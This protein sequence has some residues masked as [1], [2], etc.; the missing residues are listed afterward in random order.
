M[1]NKGH[2]W[3]NCQDVIETITKYK[4][5]KLTNKVL[6]GHPSPIFWN[7]DLNFHEFM[8]HRKQ[9][10]GRCSK[11][12]VL[13]IALPFCVPTNPPNCGYCL[14]PHVNY[15][16]QKDLV[17]YLNYLRI[18]GRIYKEYLHQEEIAA[19]YFGG[20]TPNVYPE[21][22]YDEIMDIVEEQFPQIKSQTIEITFEGIPSLFNRKK[23]QTLKSRGVTRI[24]MGVQQLNP[25]LINLSGRKQDVSHV[26]N[27]INWCH[28]LDLKISADLIYG[29]PQQTIDSM[30]YD[31]NE[32]VKANVSQITNY[33][34]NIGGRTDFSRNRRHELPTNKVNLSMFL[35]LKKFLEEHEYQQVSTNDFIRIEKNGSNIFRFEKCMR[36][37]WNTNGEMTGYDM[38]GWGFGGIS[39]FLGNADQPGVAFMNTTNLSDYYRSIEKNSPPIKRTFCYSKMDL[40]LGWIFQSLQNLGIKREVYLELFQT[41]VYDDYTLIWQALEK[42]GMAEITD[43]EIKL[44]GEGI[45]YTSLIQNLLSTKRNNELREKQKQ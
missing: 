19:I 18:E 5:K 26:L 23:L 17:D 22:L 32:L 8:N 34:L 28:E 42:Q 10:N 13:Y 25:K 36:E 12:L 6:H 43:D 31:L 45:Y 4:S 2:L 3:H 16:C 24:S 1:K 11:K 15:T 41:D 20:G 40:R 39:Y 37:F 14:F 7:H 38:W 27:V 35:T 21:T 9:I 30:L 33:E 44:L 29:W